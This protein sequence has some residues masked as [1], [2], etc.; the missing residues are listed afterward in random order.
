MRVLHQQDHHYKCY[1]AGQA[2]SVLLGRD[3]C[4]N[5]NCDLIEKYKI[6]VADTAI[7]V[8]TEVGFGQYQIHPLKMTSTNLRSIIE[9]ETAWITAL[10]AGAVV[11]LDKKRREQVALIAAINRQPV[12]PSAIRAM[13]KDIGDPP[14][15][16][17]RKRATAIVQFFEDSRG[18]NVADFNEIF[19]NKDSFH[20][21][22]LKMFFLDAIPLKPN[23][24]LTT[25][26]FAGCHLFDHALIGFVHKGYKNFTGATLVGIDFTKNPEIFKALDMHSDTPPSCTNFEGCTF[27]LDQY[28]FLRSYCAASVSIVNESISGDRDYRTITDGDEF[29]KFIRACARVSLALLF[30]PSTMLNS[31]Q[32]KCAVQFYHISDTSSLVHKAHILYAM[33]QTC[34]AVHAKNPLLAQQL[35]H[36][37]DAYGNDP[38]DA[39]LRSFCDRVAGITIGCVGTGRFSMPSARAFFLDEIHPDIQADPNFK[40]IWDA[41]TKQGPIAKEKECLTTL[42]SSTEPNS[43][44]EIAES[45]KI[46]MKAIYLSHARDDSKVVAIFGKNDEHDLA[47]IRSKMQTNTSL[48]FFA[49]ISSASA[50]T[51]CDCSA[52]LKSYDA[53]PPAPVAAPAAPGV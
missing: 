50:K 32:F 23:G 45:L 20:D 46:L 51:L 24:P 6:D 2:T 12:S 53:L 37:K 44:A 33:Q 13:L 15:T 22:F 26:S 41:A 34:E 42:L 52:L 48:H 43:R 19:K 1:I 29:T 38:T 47:T 16:A 18:F 4:F 9:F 5:A 35:Q 21:D 27:T 49:F 39:T 36:Y 25:A 10:N 3:R 14:T 7:P 11:D 8:L 28:R 30:P 31:M 17:Q 40:K